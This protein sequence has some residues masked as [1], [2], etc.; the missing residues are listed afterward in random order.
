[1]KDRELKIST[2]LSASIFVFYSVLFFVYQIVKR[3]LVWLLL[4]QIEMHGKFNVHDYA[5]IDC[6]FN[7][8]VRCIFWI[9]ILREIRAD[10]VLKGSCKNYVKQIFEFFSQ[11]AWK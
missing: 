8:P 4:K 3:R 5:A 9:T 1:M 11:F 6:C 7:F 10:S 2:V